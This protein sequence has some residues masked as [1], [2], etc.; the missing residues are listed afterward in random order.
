MPALKVNVEIIQGA[1]WQREFTVKK[2]DGSDFDMTGFTSD[3][4]LYNADRSDF[5][6]LG[7]TISSN[8]L[9]VELTDAQSNGMTTSTVSDHWLDVKVKSPQGL[10]YPI[11]RGEA[12][13]A[14]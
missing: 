7:T 8:K 12:L 3:A 5:A 13:I 14:F 9:T 11:A 1:T 4:R 10:V 6:L 2:E